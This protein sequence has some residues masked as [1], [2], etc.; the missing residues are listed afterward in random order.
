MKKICAAVLLILAVVLLFGV[1]NSSP[2]EPEPTP[3]RTLSITADGMPKKENL[4][5]VIADD[6]RF[7]SS[8]FT[9]NSGNILGTADRNELVEV[10]GE[11]GDFYKIKLMDGRYGYMHKDY[12]TKADDDN[13]YYLYLEKGTYTLTVYKKDDDGRSL[14]AIKAFKAAHGGNKTPNGKF[15]LM[16]KERWHSFPAGGSAQYAIKYNNNLYIHSTLYERED[17]T[18]MRREYYDG[19]KGIGKTSTGGCVRITVS[20]SKFIY[21]N[22]PEGTVIE[23][24]NGSPRGTYSAEI[25][26]PVKNNIDPTDEETMIR[27]GIK[28]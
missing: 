9:Q 5:I 10:I 7:R 24:V 16:K 14:Q 1:I 25:P 15:Y 2:K 4:F 11:E 19:E 12:L 20:A 18:T 26:T 23:I 17:A 27:A 28:R 6:V 13:P 8:P 22:C 3:L 21:E